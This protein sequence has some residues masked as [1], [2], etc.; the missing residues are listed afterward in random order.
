MGR[1]RLDLTGTW[2]GTLEVLHQTGR[3]VHGSVCWLT[4]CRLCKREQE[5]TAGRLREGRKCRCQ[6]TI[7]FRDSPQRQE[8]LALIKQMRADGVSMQTIAGLCG[9]TTARI[10]Q[11]LNLKEEREHAASA[12]QSR[13]ARK[14]RR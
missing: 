2:Y 13:P 5:M 6:Q 3:L 8:R 10:Y 4:R 11:L 9:V 14:A 1:K 7:I 12:K